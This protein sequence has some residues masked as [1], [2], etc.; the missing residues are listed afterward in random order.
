MAG[1]TL[2]TAAEGESEM[3]EET[4]REDPRKETPPQ[5][6]AEPLSDQD[7]EEASGGYRP[8]GPVKLA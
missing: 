7:L 6:R 2:E 1:E 5:E 4:L 8:V 3:K